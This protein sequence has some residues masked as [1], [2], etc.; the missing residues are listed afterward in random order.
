MST[1]HNQ[2]TAGEIA[3]TVLMPGDPLRTKYI[4][5]KYLDNVRQF[6]TVR[7]MFGYTGTY[8]GKE[9]SVMGSGMGMPSIGIY[10][11]ELFTQYG[12][13]NII[14]IGSAGAYC[15]KLNVLDLVLAD[16][17]WSESTFAK[18]QSGVESDVIYPNSDLNAV[19]LHSA[20]KLGKNI[21]TCKIHSSDVFYREN[22]VE[23]YRDIYEKH[24]CLCVE[25]ESFALFHNANVLGKKAACLLTIS[26]SFVSKLELSAK[27]RETSFDDMMLV[28]LETAYTI[29]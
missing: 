14:R 28:A 1:P 18:T 23:N 3:R 7:N 15:D 9:V 12:V 6:N 24:N 2:A 25:M 27:Q 20:E 4:A 17:A 19:I 21:T 16:S 5:E 29:D 26:D 10:S 13:E 11:Y 22:N 8:K